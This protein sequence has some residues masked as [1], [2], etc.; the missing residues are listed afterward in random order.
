MM[1]ETTNPEIMCLSGGFC[2]VTLLPVC[3]NLASILGFHFQKLPEDFDTEAALRRYP[4]S[5]EESMNAVLV[6]EM[7]RFNK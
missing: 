3:L 6:Q 2:H 7:E 1:M 4:V 5:Y